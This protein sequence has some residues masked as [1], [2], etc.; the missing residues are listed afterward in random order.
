MFGMIMPAPLVQPSSVTSARPIAHRA[1]RGLGPLV[2]GED[3]VGEVG[4]SRRRAGRRQPPRCRRRR[5]LIG[6]G[7][8]MTP[9]DATSTIAPPLQPTWVAAIA[10]I[11]LGVAFILARA[12]ARVGV[13][14]VDDDAAEL[15]PLVRASCAAD[16]NTGAALTLV[17]GEHRRGAARP[18]RRDDADVEARLLLDAA[19]RAG[20]AKARAGHARGR[21]RR[22]GHQAD[23]EVALVPFVLFARFVMRRA[24]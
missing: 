1:A 21:D 14:A 7:W 18:A 17:L 15:P 11:A 8:P 16:S 5:W 4:A 20:E 9:V 6:S 10:A 2:G 22:V 13:A 12:G 23:R 24:S 3:G 19:A